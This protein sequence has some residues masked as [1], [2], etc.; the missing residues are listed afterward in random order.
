LIHNPSAHPEYRMELLERLFSWGV[1]RPVRWNNAFIYASSFSYLAAALTTLMG[2]P[3]MDSMI[4]PV[5]PQVAFYLVAFLLLLAS[6]VLISIKWVVVGLYGMT[7]MLSF[8]GLQPWV[9]YLGET[10][11][12]G[13]IM[14]GLDMAL[15]VALLVEN[16]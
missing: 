4:L 16:D 7:A 2:Y 10:N 1:N 11:L 15:A 6:E 13:P 9:C 14:A 8:S 5:S 3:I 12:L